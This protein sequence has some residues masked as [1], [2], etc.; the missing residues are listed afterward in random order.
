MIGDSVKDVETGLA[1][2]C[3]TVLLSKDKV[4]TRPNVIT[5]DLLSA[6]KKIFGNRI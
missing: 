2:D 3:R 6:V 5:R 4:D 1:S